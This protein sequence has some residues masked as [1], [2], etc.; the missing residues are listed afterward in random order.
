MVFLPHP[1]F[2]VSAFLHYFI[3]PFSSAAAAADIFLA[4]ILLNVRL[5]TFQFR[6]EFS[7]K[8]WRKNM[9]ERSKYLPVLNENLSRE[10]NVLRTCE[11]HHHHH[12][13]HHHYHHH[14]HLMSWSRP[15]C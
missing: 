11:I 9:V 6:R 3:L 12:H 5:I 7:Y 13:H 10:Q 15:T 14:H 2:L 8:F 4:R 1:P